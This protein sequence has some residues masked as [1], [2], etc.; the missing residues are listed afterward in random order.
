M[1]A[2]TWATHVAKGDRFAGR[3][4][5]PAAFCSVEAL[6]LKSLS[7]APIV[8]DGGRLVNTATAIWEEKVTPV[9]LP[10]SVRVRIAE[11]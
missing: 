11:Q 3:A 7:A 4:I 9:Y 10:A 2:Q 1:I 8:I 6:W 5:V